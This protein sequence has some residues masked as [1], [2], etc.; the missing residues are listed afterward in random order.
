M[1]A[2]RRRL[3]QV[4]DVILNGKVTFTAPTEDKAK[5]LAE[6]VQVAGCSLEGMCSQISNVTIQA[7]GYATNPTETTPVTPP[8]LTVSQLAGGEAGTLTL[9]AVY[10]ENGVPLA[11][12]I[13]LT[14]A[15][16]GVVSC[17]ASKQGTSTVFT[18]TIL[19][20][21]DRLV[22]TATGFNPTAP[23]DVVKTS[24]TVFNL[25]EHLWMLPKELRPMFELA[26]IVGEPSV[27]CTQ[28]GVHRLA[29]L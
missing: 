16:N 8:T 18:C 6:K 19:Q 14:A 26:A 20:A 11:A 7:T 1:Q 22:L 17:A 10:A 3:L 4:N 27:R 24:L 15:A 5:A 2:K 28:H 25:G 29:R 13:I 21:A 23:T 9:Q 12:T